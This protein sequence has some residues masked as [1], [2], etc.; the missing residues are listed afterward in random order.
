M[1][2]TMLRLSFSLFLVVLLIGC[3]SPG[4]VP[5]V[6]STPSSSGQVVVQTVVEAEKPSAPA[7]QEVAVS[8]IPVTVAPAAQAVRPDFP[9][10]GIELY[11]LDSKGG[12]ALAA[13]AG[14]YWLRRNGLLWSDVEPEEGQRKWDAMAGLEQELKNAS[15]AHLQVILVVRSTPAWAQAMPG[16]FCGSILLDK[17]PAFT[18][19]MQDLVARYSVPPYNVKYWEVWNEP[20][21][22][23]NLASATS[24]YGCWGEQKDADYGGGTYA[25]ML[26][27][28]YPKIKAADP[29]AQVMVGGLLLDCD[30]VTPPQGRDCTPARYIEGILRNGGGEFFDGVSFHAYDYYLGPYQYGNGN[31]NSSWNTTGPSLIAKGRY[32]QKTLAAYGYPDKFLMNTEDGLICGKTGEEAECATT[33]FNLTKAYYI[34]E[35]YAASQAEGQRANIWY[36]LFGWRASELAPK[37]AVSGDQKPY[38]AYEAF[39]FGAIQLPGAAFV[40]N[41]ADIPGVKGY[42]F[43]KDGK[44]L[45]F[46]WSLD[47][48]PHSIQLPFRPSALSDVFGASLAPDQTITITVAP[49]YL[50]WNP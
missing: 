47:G 6:T 9:I 33:E 37:G 10:H 34:A 31:W 12:L 49:V 42:E 43:E 26:K 7:T 28:V 32:L 22:D 13:Q 30:P 35:S 15:E 11:S 36:S 1:A 21:V 18:R 24:L 20:D 25:T 45:W 23:H 8:P 19:F 2:K 40:R 17:L 14:A 50:E 29:Q 44:R 39:R 41:I 38:P 3:T 48:N 5:S 46:V 16:Y 4:A 27:Q